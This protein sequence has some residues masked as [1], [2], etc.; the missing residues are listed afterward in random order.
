MK[1]EIYVPEDLSEITLGQYQ[2]FEKLNTE[3][4]KDSAFLLQKMVEI[5]CKLNLQ[6]VLQIKVRSL[7][8][9][10]SHLN[11]IFE[12]EYKLVETFSLEGVKYGF[13]PMLDDMTLGE[14][15]DLDNT[16]GEWQE[17]HKA[18]SIL[19]RPITFQRNNKYQIEEYKG[20]DNA[21]VF[22]NMPLDVAFGSMVFFWNLKN[23]LLTN[24]LSFLHMESKGN[25]TPQ[26]LE[27]LE[28]SGVGISQSMDLLKAMLP[29][30]IRL[31]N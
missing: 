27:A 24:I 11:E 18:M 31:P 3:E 15:I 8:G 29:N 7:N 22:K 28:Q 4:N 9:I 1:V 19:Y 16:L 6:D 12:K 5:F 10:V 14:Y 21:E 30:L 25:L 13:C 2:K 17:M 26:Q 20:V 23:E